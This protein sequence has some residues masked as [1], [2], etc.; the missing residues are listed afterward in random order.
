[1]LQPQ[2]SIKPQP[3]PRH[4]LCPNPLTHRFSEHN[5]PED[6]YATSVEDV[7][8]V[9][10]AACSL[11]GHCPHKCPSSVGKPPCP[12]LG[13]LLGNPALIESQSSPALCEPTRRLTGTARPPTWGLWARTPGT[14][15]KTSPADGVSPHPESKH[16]HWGQW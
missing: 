14:R 1:M 15:I 8:N 13:A 10:A 16:L 4:T 6:V 5:K 3:P 12:I 11:W 9:V 7:G 2:T